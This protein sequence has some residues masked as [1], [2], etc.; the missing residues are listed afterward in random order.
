MPRPRLFLDQPIAANGSITLEGDRA[1]YLSRVLRVAP[2]AELAVFADGDGDYRASVASIGRREVR[3]SIGERQPAAA[4]SPLSVTLL[5]GV[6]RG[7]RMGFVVQKATELGAR[8]IVPVQTEFSVVK[9]DS[10][11]AERRRAHW[12]NVARSACEQSGRC[13]VP[14]IEPPTSLA[15]ALA[16]VS[17]ADARL[18]FVPSAG[19]RLRDVQRVDGE[20][21][22]LVGPEGG[23]SAAD[24]DAAVA[25][26]FRAVSLG[27][28]I[29]RTETA[30]LAALA[31]LQASWGDL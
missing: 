27:P 14:R 19:E 9:L 21:E 30:A 12:Q 26:G 7:E 17:S 25:A 2:G 20:A 31:A 28:R 4:E 11:R 8:R 3:L 6:A 18:V 24:L 10:R 22:I 5:Q 1:H 16:A 29:L 23:L 13:H 15:T